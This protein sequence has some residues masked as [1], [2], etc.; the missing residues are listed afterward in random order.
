MTA[1]GLPIHELIAL[2]QKMLDVAFSII[3]EALVTE[4]YASAL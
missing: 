1:C 3:E 2:T 4:V